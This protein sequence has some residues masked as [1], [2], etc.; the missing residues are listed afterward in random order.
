MSPD[1]PF[2]IAGSALA[3]VALG[4]GIPA[5]IGAVHFAR[6][7]SIWQL[8][9]FPSY[10]PSLFAQRGVRLSPVGLMAAFAAVCTLAAADAA[11][12][13]I[14]PS[15][16]AGAVAAVAGLLLIVAPGVFWIGFRLPFG[17]PFGI[18]AAIAI[19]IGLVI[20]IS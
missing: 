10:D 8:W 15:T 19:V 14:A 13:L 1:I 20:W 6:T 4:F 2:R 16:T 7:G 12:L 18:I 9:G 5:V 11:V 17:P 3:F